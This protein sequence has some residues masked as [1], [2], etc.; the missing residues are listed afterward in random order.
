MS[1]KESLLSR[2]VTW[3]IILVLAVLALKVVGWVVR[4]LIGVVGLVF[5]LVLALLFTVGPILL[6]GWLAMKGW[7]AFTKPA[8]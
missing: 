5:G 7:K 4:F 2:I 3:T 1:E 6:V 8:P